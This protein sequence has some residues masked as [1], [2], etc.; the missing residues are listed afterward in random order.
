MI[1]WILNLIRALALR[2]KLRK[3]NRLAGWKYFKRE[4]RRADEMAHFNNKRYRVY[5]YDKYVSLT[6]DDVVA[7]KQQKQLC[8]SQ[9][10]GVLSKNAF[11]DTQNHIITHPEFKNRKILTPN[12]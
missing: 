2:A 8:K 4:C 10:L 12:P 3:M 5:L 9:N 1:K 6:S 11:Y 7:L